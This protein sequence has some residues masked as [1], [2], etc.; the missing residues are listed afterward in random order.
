[1]SLIFIPKILRYANLYFFIQNLSEWHLSNRKKHNKEWRE[2]L[3]FS[4]EVS[5]CI[6]EFKAKS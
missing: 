5:S 2:E 4:A 6:K 1:M 3:S